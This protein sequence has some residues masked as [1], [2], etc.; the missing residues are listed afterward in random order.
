MSKLVPRTCKEIS[1]GDADSRQDKPSRPLE[2]FRE[3]PVYVLLGDPGAGKTTAFETES[4]AC[5]D[6]C[7]ISAR[8]FIRGRLD[9]HPEW[10][11]KTLFV[12]GLDEV[13]AG[14]NDPRDALDRIITK[15]ERLGR[16]RFRL[17]CRAIDWLGRN[18]QKELVDVYRDVG[19]TV[20]QLDSLNKPDIAKILQARPDIADAE[21]FMATAQERGI[22]G[23]LTNA[24]SLNFLADVVTKNG[25]WP[26]SRLEL[27][28][29]A[30]FQMAHEHND[31]HAHAAP[32]LVPAVAVNAAGHL[33]AVQLI[34]RKAGY[35]LHGQPDVESEYPT[36]DSFGADRHGRF[37]LALA[38]KLFGGVSDNRFTSVHRHIAEFLGA[39]Y[40]AR[41]IGANHDPLPARRVVALM[42]GGD[43]TVVSEMRGLSAWLAAHCPDARADLIERDPIGVGLYGDI[44]N[45]SPAEK[46]ALLKSL[47]RE[48]SRLD[49]VWTSAAFGPIATPDLQPVLKEILQET[50]RNQDHQTFTD[51]ILRVLEHGTPM[52]GLAGILLA[53]VRDTTRWPHVNTSALLAFIH[54]CPEGPNKTSKLKALLVDIHRGRVSDPDSELLGILLN[55]LYPHEITPLE[56]WDYL[57]ETRDR[58]RMYFGAYHS[59]WQTSLLA[60]SSDKQIPDLLDYLPRQHPGFRTHS[61]EE[62]P[63]KLLARGL[64]TCGDQ[65]AAARL[66]YWLGTGEIEDGYWG[67]SEA[68][69]EIRSWLEQRPEVQKA[70]ILEGLNRCPAAGEIRSDAFKTYERFYGVERPSDFALWCLKQATGLANTRPRVAVYL[71]EEAFRWREREGLA[72]GVL[73]NHARKSATLRTCLDKLIA[74]EEQGKKEELQYRKRLRTFTEERR[75]RGKQ[76]PDRVRENE[77]ALR[78]NRAA[79][80]LLHHMA[81]IYFKSPEEAVGN[82]HP[83]AVSPQI[84]RLQLERLRREGAGFKGLEALLGGDSRL[85][86]AALQGLRGTLHRE[87]VPDVGEILDLHAE[88]RVHYLGWPYLAALEEV[89]RT[90]PEQD[91]SRWD[92]GQARKALAF[93][94]CNPP[95]NDPPEW[96]RHLL[97]THPET[98]ADVQVK[99]A[100]REFRSGR[101]YVSKLA[102]IAYDPEYA[103]VAK[104]TSL[105]L[106][107]AFPTR[108]KL[109]HLESLDHLLWTAIQYADK[110]LLRE[111]IEKKLLRTSMNDTQ[112]LRWL[113]AGFAI[114]PEVYG[115]LLSQFAKRHERWSR[116]LAEFFQSR[117][118]RISSTW[119]KGMV[120]SA[121]ARLINI[122]GSYVGPDL[123]KAQGWITTS[124]QASQLVH[125]LIQHNLAASSDNAASLA[126]ASLIEDPA[127]HPWRDVLSQAQDT[128]RVI[129]RDA[130]FRHPTIE[131]IHETLKDGTP[132]NA[133]DLAALMMDRLDKIAGQIATNNANYWR[134]YW[135]E[136]PK[137]QKPTDPKHENSCRDVLV[138]DLRLFFPN[139]EP[140][141]QYVDNKRADIRVI[142]KNFHVPVEI[143]KNSHPDLWSALRSQLIEQYTNGA[144]E[145]DGYG[146]YLVFWFGKKY[147]QAPPSGKRPGS[148]AE[149]EERLKEEARLSPEESR[150]ISV[151]V[152]DVSKP[153]P[154]SAASLS[155][156]PR[157]PSTITCTPTASSRSRVDACSTRA[158]R[159]DSERLSHPGT[160]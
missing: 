154:I 41:I 27:F 160:S 54:N 4:K 36:L 115:D 120:I 10:R 34:A 82:E 22:D 106:L 153:N 58:E 68:K 88:G 90:E 128:Q 114:A 147:T 152:I 49:S 60:K 59:F 130:E 117:G 70:L 157:A 53:V 1:A 97:T 109:K 103:K 7:H 108:C 16:P 78:E 85:S 18:D 127:L 26:K 33:C 119:L 64:Q 104:Y 116:H 93:Y 87:D 83:F 92:D 5:A 29:K 81:S 19:V 73:R 65:L 121:S 23:F 39:R 42:K 28:E 151:R 44:R 43:G 80:V 141:V 24:Q 158:A 132:T 67:D 123:R 155:A 139:A 149:L 125:E 142:H 55:Q 31:E 89:V 95:T 159:F 50:N 14:G 129:R 94:L 8:R 48:A 148:A 136:D 122:L 38:T 45:F 52:S 113:S 91:P 2:A 98:V 105:P 57:S 118:R 144:P 100:S 124:M 126:L 66:Y 20:L 37:R 21:T 63:L 112:R 77:T 40:L 79:P 56:V 84:R 140:E 102:E 12:D 71:F 107:R 134:P 76:W 74:S 3:T 137:T 72:L 6:G 86:D 62:L 133:G 30:C 143:K 138:H 15:L 96:Y 131:Q 99:F 11:G 32:V 9:E 101:E 35:T 150:K 61:L 25:E 13:R 156:S 69:Q 135:N 17:S 75:Q 47:N 110:A 145:T 51:F 111:L 46:R 146:I